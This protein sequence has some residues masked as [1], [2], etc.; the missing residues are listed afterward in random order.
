LIVFT[1]RSAVWVEKQDTFLDS[2][3]FADLEG[4]T[5]RWLFPPSEFDL[6]RCS[7]QSTIGYE[8]NKS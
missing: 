8:E 4:S 5:L 7:R 3:A 6:P 2:R 1:F